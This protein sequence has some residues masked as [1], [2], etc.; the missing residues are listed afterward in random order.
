MNQKGDFVD[1]EDRKYYLE[2]FG[3]DI[4]LDRIHD[5]NGFFYERSFELLNDNGLRDAGVVI[6]A[7]V[8]DQGAKVTNRIGF[9]CGYNVG[10]VT[11]IHAK[12]KD[13]TVREYVDG[14]F[15]ELFPQVKLPNTMKQEIVEIAENQIRI[16]LVPEEHFVALCSF[17]EAIA[18]FGIF[19]LMR[20]SFRSE[21]ENPF[22]YRFGFDRMMQTQVLGA[23]RKV[24][25]DLLDELMSEFLSE[26]FD[27]APVI[28]LVKVFDLLNEMYGLTKMIVT[29]GNYKPLYILRD[30]VPGPARIRIIRSLV[31]QV[32]SLRRTPGIYHNLGQSS[33]KVLEILG[34]D[35]F[36]NEELLEE[37]NYNFFV[38]FHTDRIEF[39]DS[40]LYQKAIDHG[41]DPFE[42][43][44]KK[45]YAGVLIFDNVNQERDLLPK[46]LQPTRFQAKRIYPSKMKE[47]NIPQNV[48]LE[49]HVG[50]I[51]FDEG[52]YP[53]GMIKE[54]VKKLK[55][56]K[57][58]IVRYLA[59][60][61]RRVK[62]NVNNNQ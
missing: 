53:S 42:F 31:K 47:Q 32:G 12:V 7:R 4:L 2:N 56:S 23:L 43:K 57:S 22:T 61:W 21:R 62:K 17:V 39:L 10:W 55:K 28:W 13:I 8:I 44:K 34:S 54:N 25:P 19:N 24:C 46:H 20:E 40:S 41:I 37:Q 5:N 52:V 18:N 3:L 14:K 16:N 50:G 48:I 49:R 30:R 51:V 45:R 27:S 26:L 15:D 60:L 38:Q 36:E 59:K 58:R 35:L 33:M 11:C 6:C 29:N 9:K 1:T